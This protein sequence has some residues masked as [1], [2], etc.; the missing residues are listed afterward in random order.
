MAGFVHAIHSI[1]KIFFHFCLLKPAPFHKFSF[2][3][4]IFQPQLISEQLKDTHG[5]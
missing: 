3:V 5:G 1:V 4:N 2:P